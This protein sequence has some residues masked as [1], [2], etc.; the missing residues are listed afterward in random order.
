M[1]PA[2]APVPEPKVIITG[3]GRAGTTLLVQVL[4]DLGLDTGYTSDAEGDR[5]ARLAVRAPT[6]GGDAGLRRPRG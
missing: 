1:D 5:S 4:T 3:T 6:F 2:E